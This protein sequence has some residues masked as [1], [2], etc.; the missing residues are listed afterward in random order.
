MKDGGLDFHTESVLDTHRRSEVT[1]QSYLIEG[2][3]DSSTLSSSSQKK[4]GQPSLYELK[5]QQISL[6]YVYT[7]ECQKVCI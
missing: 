1:D 4:R 7:Y 2:A 6:V 3:S 5:V